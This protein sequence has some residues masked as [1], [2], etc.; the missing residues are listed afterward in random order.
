MTN[1]LF[2]LPP[3]LEGRCALLGMLVLVDSEGVA[4]ISRSSLL[5]ERLRFFLSFA[6]GSFFCEEEAFFLSG[7]SG[8]GHSTSLEKSI[9]EAGIHSSRR[10]L[11]SS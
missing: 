4:E 1:S 3:A 11:K 9:R 6:E 2:S 10:L 5:R 8:A 7:F